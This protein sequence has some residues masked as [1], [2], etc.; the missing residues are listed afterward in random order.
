MR[1]FCTLQLHFDHPGLHFIVFFKKTYVLGFAF[2]SPIPKHPP[3]IFIVFFAFLCREP[4]MHPTGALVY[5]IRLF[6]W[7][8]IHL[9]I[10]VNCDWDFYCQLI[11]YWMVYFS[12][13]L[14]FKQLFISKGLNSISFL[15]LIDNSPI[16]GHVG[17]SDPFYPSNLIHLISMYLLINLFYIL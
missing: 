14:F 2:Y 10:N 1:C 5:S 3:C 12:S 17:S 11:D 15:P 4:A 7:K 8:I 9:A 16:S 6:L 13:F